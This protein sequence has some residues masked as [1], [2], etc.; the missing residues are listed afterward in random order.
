MTD[1]ILSRFADINVPGRRKPANRDK[2]VKV[3]ETPDWDSKPVKYMV[4]GV[5][6]EFF[7]IG[8]LARALGYSVQSIRA[9]EQQGLMPKSPYRSPKPRKEQVPGATVKGRRLWT[10]AQIEGILRIAEEMGVVLNR[11]PPTKAFAIK[12]NNLYAEL[13]QQTQ[14][15]SQ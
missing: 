2:P 6:V 13:T 4:K 11:K 15:Q 9:W 7:T 1:P 10:R 3:V 8:H 5:M 12:V 14:N